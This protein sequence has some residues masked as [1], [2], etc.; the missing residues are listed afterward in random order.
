MLFMISLRQFRCAFLAL[1]LV[2]ALCAIAV[3]HADDEDN[4]E[5]TGTISSLP[6]TQGFIGDWIV[7]GRTVHVTSATRIE[8]EEGSP[9][10]GKTVEVEGVLQ[11]D[12]SVSATEIE[13]KDNAENDFEFRGRVEQ[14]PSTPGFIGD[15]RV[16]G[17]IVHVTSATIIRQNEAPL[18]LGVL[19]KVVGTLRPD[20]TID[21]AK[22][23]TESNEHPP[24][25]EFR[26]A[27][28]ALQNTP[29]LTGDWTVGGR[30]V[31][32]TPLTQIERE[33]GLIRIGTIV[34]VKGTVRIDGSVDAVKIDADEDENQFEFHGVINSLPNTAGFIGDWIVDGRT[35]HVTTS[36]RIDQEEGLVAVGA[37][38]EVK[39][40]LRGDGSVDAAR[41]EVE[42]S[43]G[44]EH[45][46]PTLELEGTVEQLPNTSN[47]VG[48]WIVS[49]RIVHVSSATLIRPSTSAITV[50]TFVEIEGTLRTDN[51][52]DAL[53]VE[54]ERAEDD[55]PLV[56]FLA[57]FGTVE[58]LPN[59]AEFVGDWVVSGRTIHVSSGTP[60]LTG[61]RPLVVGSFVRVVGT[62]RSDGSIDAQ[63][64]QVK[65]SDNTGRRLNFFEL[66]GTVESTPAS[67]LIGDYRI[68]GLIVHT[69]AATHF[70]PRDKVIAIGSRVKVVGRLR[71]DGTLDAAAIVV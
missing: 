49:G 27:V 57:L 68:S 46:V 45:R 8:Q 36:T 44:D 37:F 50:G 5:F 14:L 66:F 29:D 63:I 22:V 65:R 54:V 12:G 28:Q 69:S 24:F 41:I 64:I 25:F 16:A 26:G 56:P 31:H 17:R 35:V 53:S 18:A 23:K 39:G 19:V 48:D 62:L 58:V 51:T 67:G 32:V 7:A 13:V 60:I 6:N 43:A 59:T 4:F 1:L 15:W 9:A 10:V 3:V 30:I 20:G 33:D 71:T 42:R 38:V 21:A 70:A 2:G 47:L 34:E 11:P 55:R 61:H 52:I 40:K